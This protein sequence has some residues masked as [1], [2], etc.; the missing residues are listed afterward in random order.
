MS[1]RVGNRGLNRNLNERQTKVLFC[2]VKEYIRT[3]KPVSSSKVLEI[4][5]IDY[6]SATIRNDM[7]KLEYLGYLKQPHTSAGRIPTDKALRFYL[8]VV[9]DMGRMRERG[10]DVE[11]DTQIYWEGDFSRILEGAVKITSVASDG[12][13]IVEKPKVEFLRIS[14]VILREIDETRTLVVLSTELGL[15]ESFT[16]YHPRDARLEELEGMLNEKLV[17]RTIGEIRRSISRIDIKTRMWYDKRLEELVKFFEN[18][19]RERFEEGFLR[20]G[21]Q[22]IINNDLLS[23]DAVRKLMRILEDE[24]TM[25]RFLNEVHSLDRKKNGITVT[26]GEEHRNRDLKEFSTFVSTY[27][28]FDRNVG[29]IAVITS[30]YTDYEKVMKALIYISNR[31]TEFLTKLSMRR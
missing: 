19:L 23:F 11:K 1:G 9:M 25:K 29:R 22:R 16:V 5:T 24:E 18:L 26:I 6:S 14:R 7:R 28:I 30:K 27:K 12:I 4:S 21:F 3:H 31:L 2:I 13:A 10:K 17:G 20:Y 15:N 8:D